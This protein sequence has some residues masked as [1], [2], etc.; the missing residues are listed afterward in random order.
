MHGIIVNMN[1]Y[2][3]YK[4]ELSD[5]FINIF[6]K[7]NNCHVKIIVKTG[8]FKIADVYNACGIENVPGFWI[9]ISSDL[10]NHLV[11][12]MHDVVQVS[13]SVDPVKL[14]HFQFKIFIRLAILHI[15]YFLQKCIL[16]K[17]LYFKNRSIIFIKFKNKSLN[18]LWKE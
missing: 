8:N 10:V 11:I 15:F 7:N 12:E 13:N 1:A 6:G 14:Y 3:E 4:V 16:I 18:L 9:R 2:F 5:I 17:L